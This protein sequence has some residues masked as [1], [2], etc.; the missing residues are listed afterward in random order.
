LVREL[1]DENAVLFLWVPSPMLKRCFAVIEAWGFDYKASF[2]W[3]KVKHVMGHYNS[4]RH[5]FLLICT[6]GSCKPDVPKLIDSVQ[7]I[8]RR[9][10]HS[11]KP[12]QFRKII[13]QMYDHGRKLELFARERRDGWDSD[14]NEIY[15]AIAA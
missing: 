13:E 9:G 6:C 1:A 4:V 15:D 10:K 2:V 3:H 5:E 12:E 14:G 8:E 7:V 11:E